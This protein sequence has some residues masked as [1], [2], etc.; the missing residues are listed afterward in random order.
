MTREMKES[1]IEWI[2][3]IPKEWK[4]VRVSNLFQERKAPNRLG[5]ES[6]RL[7]LSYGYIIRK[8]I[9]SGEGLLPE[10]FNTYN[11]IEP[12]DIIIRPTDL[13]N[14]KTSLRTGLSKEHGIITSAYIALRPNSEN[15][16][17]RYFHYLLHSYDL[18]KVFY[19]MGNG[20]RQGLTFNLFS[21][22]LLIEPSLIEQQSIADYLDYKCSQ[23]DSLVSNIEAQITKLDE[24]R[25][26]L[27][28][29]TVTK[30]LD[31]N[32]EM[33]DSGIEWIG[34]IPKDWTTSKAKYLL[35]QNCPMLSVKA[36]DDFEFIYLDI[37]SIEYGKG[38]VKLDH[39]LFKD[40][41]SRARRVVEKDDVI[42]STVR[43]YLK[44]IALIPDLGA[45]DSIIASTG[46]AVLKANKQLLDPKYLYFY[47]L[48]D[49]FTSRIEQVSYGVAYP[50][51][52][53]F[54]VRNQPIILP[55]IKEQIDIANYLDS[56]CSK[57]DETV[58]AKESLIAELKDYKKTLIFDYVTGKRKFHP[59]GKKESDDE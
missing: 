54:T 1:G 42:V 28:T 25:K 33:K 53:E 2:G 29:Q 40:A 51:V 45:T 39:T 32:V 7:S 18:S 8:D 50:S 46:F 55:S 3:E 14:D 23:I 43:T 10:S 48:S 49:T 44:A 24:Y 15:I 37:S 5:Q 35:E 9:N 52:D 38:I 6:N 56:K 30:G 27:I 26:A 19:N 31:P 36:N 13:Q 21:R 11:I 47:C 4:T 22:L 16:D 34:E 57:I 58:Q 17:S 41:P 20:V 59:L 12:K